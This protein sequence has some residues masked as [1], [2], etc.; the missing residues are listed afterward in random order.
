MY[1]RNLI[2]KFLK[3]EIGTTLTCISAKESISISKLY[4]FVKGLNRNPSIEIILRKKYKVP[5][6]I[7]E[8]SFN[9]DE[10]IK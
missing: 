3:E 1:K 4:N 2:T 10:D 5:K 8:T 7:I 9:N 6:H